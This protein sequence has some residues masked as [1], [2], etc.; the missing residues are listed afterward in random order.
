M[1]MIQSRA[2]TVIATASFTVPRGADLWEDDG[3]D[4]RRF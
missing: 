2:L 3:H 4:S 1:T